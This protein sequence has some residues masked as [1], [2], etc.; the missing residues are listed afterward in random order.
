MTIPNLITLIRI[1]LTPVLIWL[2]LDARLGE[3]LAVFFVAGVTDGLDGFIARVFHQKSRLGAYLDPL[4]DKLLLVSSFILLGHLDLLPDWLV[5]IT[6]SRDALIVIGVLTLMFHQVPVAIHPS[7]L[8]K[9]TT[10]V[11]ILTVMAILAAPYFS[12]PLWVT[13]GLISAT[14]AFSVASGLHY[15]VYGLRLWDAARNGDREQA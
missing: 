12:P 15:I 9:L 1:L 7:L 10:L 3:A 8:S 5:V 4:A 6:V 13:Q 14:A 2:L 11:Q